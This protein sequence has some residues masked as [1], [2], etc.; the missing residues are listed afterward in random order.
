[1]KYIIT[2]SLVIAL[3][4]MSACLTTQQPDT[5]QLDAPGYTSDQIISIAK[6][7]N[8]LQYP[9]NDTKAAGLAAS[10]SDLISAYSARWE[11]EYNGQGLWLITKTYYYVNEAT[12]KDLGLIYE[13]NG[14]IQWLYKAASLSSKF[15]GVD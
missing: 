5:P 6:T 13:Q 8:P 12:V 3:V 9:H 15:T 1:M 14:D 2:L 10:G 4:L 7:S 11:I